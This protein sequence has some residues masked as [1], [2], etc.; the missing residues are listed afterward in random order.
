MTYQAQTRL[1]AFTQAKRTLAKIAAMSAVALSVAACKGH[2]SN[3][4]KDGLLQIDHDE[5][6]PITVSKRPATMAISVRRGAYGLLPRQQARVS[7]FLARQRVRDVGN[8]KLYVAVPSGSANEVE[9]MQAVTDL[10]HLISEHGYDTTTV[11]VS[12]YQAARHSQPPIRLSYMRFVAEGPDCGN[13]PTNLARQFDN[14]HHENYGCF[15]QKNL[16]TMVANPADLI[17]PR[18]MTP[19][20]EER[21]R[22]IWQKWQQGQSTAAERSGAETADTKK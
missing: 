15:A 16:A 2:L 3:E 17:G 18:T 6:H 5:M 14:L 19:R 12:P 4:Y 20:S 13:F 9:A 8:S 21:R 11:K 7:R 10:R 22:V 1:P